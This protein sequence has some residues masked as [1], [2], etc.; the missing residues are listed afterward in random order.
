MV[1][2]SVLS[3]DSD[4][5]TL[6]P[7]RAITGMEDLTAILAEHQAGDTITVTMVVP[8]REQA[9]EQTVQVVLAAR[10]DSV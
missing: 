2:S 8:G 3:V 7:G 4:N 9:T 1:P 6:S 5:S 10:G